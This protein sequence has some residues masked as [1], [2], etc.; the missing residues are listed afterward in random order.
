MDELKITLARFKGNIIKTTKIIED[1]LKSSDLEDKEFVQ[2]F[3]NLIKDYLD[4]KDI[5]TVFDIIR[6]CN[7][8]EDQIKQI[9]D[10]LYIDD[11]DSRKNFILKAIG[12]NFLQDESFIAAKIIEIKSDDNAREI[13]DQHKRLYAD[14]IKIWRARVQRVHPFILDAL[15]A[16]LARDCAIAGKLKITIGFAQIDFGDKKLSELFLYC[17][18][19]QQNFASFFSE[20]DLNK[21]CE[22]LYDPIKRGFTLSKIFIHPSELQYYGQMFGRDFSA[23]CKTMPQMQDLGV[24]WGSFGQSS[25]AAQ[26][27]VNLEGFDYEFY[28]A[29][30]EGE[31]EDMEDVKARIGALCNETFSAEIKK[32]NI[33]SF[34][35]IIACLEPEFIKKEEGKLYDFF[36]KNKDFLK[37]LFSQKGGLANFLSN[38]PSL[39]DEGCSANFANQVRLS[40]FAAFEPDFAKRSLFVVF[41]E[42]LFFP[43]INSGGDVI[44]KY[45]NPFTNAMIRDV[46]IEPQAFLSAL[47]KVFYDPQYKE[48]YSAEYHQFIETASPGI[49]E[50]YHGVENYDEMMAELA[51]YIILRDNFSEILQDGALVDFAEKCHEILST[52]SPLVLSPTVEDLEEEPSAKGI[53]SPVGHK[54][55]TGYNLGDVKKF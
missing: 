35:A 21:I 51:A 30:T 1:F 10:L 8:S 33:L 15:D 28:R 55:D 4:P 19:Y 18:L 25:Q 53:A 17:D 45:D 36:V 11:E 23:I 16:Y 43:L 6:L 14:K 54:F 31:A 39:Q 27:E 41:Y 29:K 20:L 48:K 22:S 32:E 37:Y 7:I 40:A 49:A 50:K 38:I 2:N 46:Y 52:N 3:C 13:L 9:C 12:G 47:K 42:K 26:S 24:V 44:F 34:F 5:S